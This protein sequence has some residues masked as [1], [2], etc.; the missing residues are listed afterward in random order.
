MRRS[1]FTLIEM[2]VVI[3]IIGIFTAVVGV[4]F[5]MIE[6]RR[7]KSEVNRLVADL[8]WAREL[9]VTQHKDYKVTFD[10][11]QNTYTITD[12]NNNPLPSRINPVRLSVNIQ[13]SPNRI[14]FHYPSGTASV[15]PAIQDSIVLTLGSRSS[16]LDI[17]EDTGYVGFHTSSSSCFIATVVY[18]SLEVRDRE[19]LLVLYTLRDEY[20]GS[21]EIG[22][23]LIDL[24]YDLSPPIAN[25]IKSRRWM[26]NTVRV[27]LDTLVWL[28]KNVIFH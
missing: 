25:Y 1:S 13:T 9:A 4:S 5:T 23:R 11:T 17:F 21:S 27:F 18:N 22:K 26:K 24:Y 28:C 20:L 19:K 15:Y 3:L 6:S 8:Q 2:I 14:E 16:R 10:R 7:L 12:I